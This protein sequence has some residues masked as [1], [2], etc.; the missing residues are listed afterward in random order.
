MGPKLEE[1]KMRLSHLPEPVAEFQKWL[2]F[3]ISTVLFADK[4]G[5]LLMLRDEDSEL[6]IDQRIHHI[7]GLAR[8]WGLSHSVLCRSQQCARVIIYDTSRV[9]KAL[10]KVPRQVFDRLGYPHNIETAEFLEEVNRRWQDKQ[11]IPHE[12]G[13]ALGYPIKDVFGYMG[14]LPLRCTGA[15]G[16]RIY[17]DPTLSLRRSHEFAKAREQAAAFLGISSG[18]KKYGGGA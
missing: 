1:W 6:S 2:F 7:A 13:L 8:S 4:T 11:Q 18:Q 14:L 17:G 5:E 10:S 15:C 9:L 12:I 3:N 16:W